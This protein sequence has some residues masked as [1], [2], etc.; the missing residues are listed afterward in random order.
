M[1][2]VQPG[3]VVVVVP[4]RGGTGKMS[5]TAAS[6]VCGVRRVGCTGD[7]GVSDRWK[8]DVVVGVEHT[9]VVSGDV[10]ALNNA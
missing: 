6:G 9:T 4:E 2:E 3:R 5:A 10:H 1:K 7:V 8:D